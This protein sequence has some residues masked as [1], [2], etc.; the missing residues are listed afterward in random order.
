MK[1]KTNIYKNYKIIDLSCIF[2]L[3][4]IIH[5]MQHISSKL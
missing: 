2:L 5:S 4:N 3:K 1:E